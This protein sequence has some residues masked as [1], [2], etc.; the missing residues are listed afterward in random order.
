MDHKFKLQLKCLKSD[1]NLEKCEVA[2]CKKAIHLSCCKKF[3]A[4]FGE[5][6][7]EG[8]LFVESA[9]SSNTKSHLML[10][11]VKPKEEFCGMMM[12]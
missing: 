7:R 10:L 5:D 1:E 6:E 11:Q 9:A 12:D 4:T 3:M 2:E 8:P